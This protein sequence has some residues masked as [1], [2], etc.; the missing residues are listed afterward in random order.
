MFS[1]YSTQ[2][3]QSTFTEQRFFFTY[4]DLFIPLHLFVLFIDIWTR[5]VVL[6]RDVA[7]GNRKTGVSGKL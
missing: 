5:H 2:L 7:D 1:K 4:C 3:Q 6:G